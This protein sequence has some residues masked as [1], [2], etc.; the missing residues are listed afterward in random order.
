MIKDVE[1]DKAKHCYKGNEMLKGANVSLPLSEEHK[2][3]LQ[4]IAKDISY[5]V[6]EY[7]NIVT[8]DKGVQ[9]FKTHPYQQDWIQKCYDNRFLIG[10]WSRQSGKCVAGNTMIIVKNKLTGKIE[11]I[12]ISELF[13]RCKRC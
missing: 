7:V 6:N 11:H 3:E 5:F 12:P 8:L 9:K 10:K 4:Q 13:A 2:S 1:I